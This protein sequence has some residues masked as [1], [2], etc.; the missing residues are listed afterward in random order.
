MGLMIIIVLGFAS[1]L[2]AM[3]LRGG[4]S[5][6][7]HLI[8]RQSAEGK[9]TSEREEDF[10][11][12]EIFVETF[13]HQLISQEWSYGRS[14]ET[15]DDYYELLERWS[16]LIT[17]ESPTLNEEKE[18]AH[19]DDL[20]VNWDEKEASWKFLFFLPNWLCIPSW[21]FGE[22]FILQL[23]NDKHLLWCLK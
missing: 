17:K 8:Y 14:I 7:R 11:R 19:L 16:D 10:Q 21:I 5:M 18:L 1:A 22:A 15:Q 4:F 23:I 6:A 13:S 12:A 2:M 20:I 3:L 9:E